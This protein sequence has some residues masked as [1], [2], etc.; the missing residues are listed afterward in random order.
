VLALIIFSGV[1]AHNHSPSF[2]KY[3]LS[4]D[5]LTAQFH[6]QS[7]QQL[8]PMVIEYDRNCKQLF[9]QL[10][11]L[12]EIGEKYYDYSLKMNE[13]EHSKNVQYMLNKSHQQQVKQEQASLQLS[14]PTKASSPRTA[15][16]RTTTAAATT[17][18][19][20]ER[21]KSVS[22]ITGRF[23]SNST[24][25]VTSRNTQ[26]N[27]QTVHSPT[28]PHS[29]SQSQQSNQQR[30]PERKEENGPSQQPHHPQT[31]PA[32]AKQQKSSPNPV[33]VQQTQQPPHKNS[34]SQNQP[35]HHSHSHPANQ[36]HPQSSAPAS[37]S[38][39]VSQSQHRSSRQQVNAASNP[40]SNNNPVNEKNINSIPS[41]QR[42]Q[43][44]QAVSHQS[45]PAHSRHQSK[46]AKKK[47]HTPEK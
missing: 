29:Q 8:H 43:S 26:A 9:A 13:L 46:Y 39:A 7:Q 33:T 2:V 44:P 11:P 21:Q 18:S 30:T 3:P 36:N 1:Y 31:P 27:S 19:P 5:S 35:Q 41:H 15:A 24:F 10:T 20:N 17:T 28:S 42:H 47:D 6:Q 45:Q 16:N 32:T 25:S 38:T 37:T 34:P 23:H 4:S 22:P 12:S 40:P 14:M